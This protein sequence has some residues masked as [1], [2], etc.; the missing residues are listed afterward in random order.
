MRSDYNYR[1]KH[2]EQRAKT[3]LYIHGGAY[4]FGSVDEH[5]YQLQR[6]ARK[7]HARV[8]ARRFD[9]CFFLSALAISGHIFYNI[10]NSAFF[11]RFVSL[12]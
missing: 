10:Y 2:P 8:F 4:Y 3:M 6:H 11:P 12:I 7:L 5:R 1:R 9:F